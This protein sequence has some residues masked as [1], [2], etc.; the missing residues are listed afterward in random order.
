MEG[1]TDSRLNVPNKEEVSPSHTILAEIGLERSRLQLCAYAGHE[2]DWL[3]VRLSGPI[4]QRVQRSLRPV[5]SQAI[6][7]PQ[8]LKPKK[9]E[10]VLR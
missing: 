9:T 6:V 1:A 3:L 10:S 8:P 4:C 5:S 2:A 7:S